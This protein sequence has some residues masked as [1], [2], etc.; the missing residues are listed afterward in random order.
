MVEFQARKKI[1]RFLYSPFTLIIMFALLLVFSHAAYSVWQRDEE[2]RELLGNLNEEKEILTAKEKNLALRIAALKTDRGVETA[3]R[4]KYKVAKEGEGV[5]VIVDPKKDE[6]GI[7]SEK[8]GF[9]AFF[10]KI[11]N[12]FK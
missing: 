7:V 12:F 5:V 11:K 9:S 10:D 6:G 2:V 8:S 1:R 4:E 3:L